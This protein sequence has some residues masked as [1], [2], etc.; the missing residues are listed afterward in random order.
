LQS[1]G[2]TADDKGRKK[3]QRAG[4]ATFG[5]K[6]KQVGVLVKD[7]WPLQCHFVLLRNSSRQCHQSPARVQLDRKMFVH[8]LI[9]CRSAVPNK[10]TTHATNTQ[11]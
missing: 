3:L 6:P 1:A 10:Q 5:K 8:L 2:S 7:Q 11:L 4:S 9:S